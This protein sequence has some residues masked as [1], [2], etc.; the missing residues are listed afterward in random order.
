MSPDTYN[1]WMIEGEDRRLFPGLDLGACA[2]SLIEWLRDARIVSNEQLDR[3]L[4][5]VDAS[6]DTRKIEG[7]MPLIWI[8]EVHG[9]LHEYRDPEFEDCF[10][11]VPYCRDFPCR[12]AVVSFALREM[13][14][15][16]A[17]LGDVRYALAADFERLEREL[18]KL[19]LEPELARIRKFATP[20]R[21]T[22]GSVW[23]SLPP[24][25]Q[26]MM[27]AF[28][29][30]E[31]ALEVVRLLEGLPDELATMSRYARAK[32][33]SKQLKQGWAQQ[34]GRTADALQTAIWQHLHEGG[35]SLREIA[36]LVPDGKRVTEDA[37]MERI[38]RRVKTAD[39]R[40]VRPWYAPAAK[41][42]L[43]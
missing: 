11:H 35:F 18:R 26:A 32:L 21:D 30:Y 24:E 7:G 23:Q 2:C 12:A 33:S 8:A 20:L 10:A 37:L 43:G 40:T 28:P 17:D 15:Y 31:R 25:G 5:V 14:S 22:V 1:R 9:Q 38:R 3:W 36:R 6:T 13:G 27:G 39:L 16:A 34:G 42:Q 19:K 41:A 29:P 4:P